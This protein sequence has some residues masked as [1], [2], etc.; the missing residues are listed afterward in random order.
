MVS[1]E[2]EPRAIARLHVLF[3]SEALPR[4]A[5]CSASGRYHFQIPISSSHFLNLLKLFTF[6]LST[7]LLR[8]DV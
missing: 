6:A 5:F 4:S 7:K 1:H 8:L 2:A 3:W